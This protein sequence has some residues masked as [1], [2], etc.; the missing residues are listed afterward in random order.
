MKTHL[1]PAE[2]LLR[3]V[4]DGSVGSTELAPAHR[5]P[6]SLRVCVASPGPS[7]HRSLPEASFLPVPMAGSPHLRP[8]EILSCCCAQSR[9]APF[10]AA[11]KA[12][13]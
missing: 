5:L 11:G 10:S 2:T 13:A 1:G 4:N 12:Q 6:W 9:L 7:I 8:Q 3:P